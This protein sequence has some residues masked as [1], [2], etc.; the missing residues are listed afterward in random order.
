MNGHNKINVAWWMWVLCLIFAWD[1][2]VKLVSYVGKGSL[3]IGIT[4]VETVI[5]ERK[6]SNSH[7]EDWLK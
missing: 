2:T 1:V 4:T 3:N 5:D 6:K 7:T